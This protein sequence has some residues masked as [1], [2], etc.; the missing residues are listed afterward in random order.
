M[1]PNDKYIGARINTRSIVFKFNEAYNTTG[2][3][4]VVFL[5]GVMM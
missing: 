1:E 4:E 3:S 5:L 2:I